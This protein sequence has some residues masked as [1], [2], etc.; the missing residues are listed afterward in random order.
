MIIKLVVRTKNC[1][2]AVSGKKGCTANP[3]WTI[4][5]TITSKIREL[6]LHRILSSL[7]VTC[8]ENYFCGLRVRKT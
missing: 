1:V 5:Q 3:E 7:R 8:G 2:Q 6:P 4:R